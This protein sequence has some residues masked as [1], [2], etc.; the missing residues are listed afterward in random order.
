MNFQ[1]LYASD[2]IRLITNYIEANNPVRKKP[3]LF[4]AGWC[5]VLIFI[6]YQVF[7]QVMVSPTG[8]PS[9]LVICYGDGSFS[10]QIANT[11]GGTMS[12]AMLFIS[13][14]AG[15]IYTP[16]SIVGATQFNISNLNQPVF[17]LPD[18]LNNTAH[19]VSYNAGLIC[20]YTN[21]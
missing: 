17:S 8:K 5:I 12:G 2:D 11:T 21:T 20:G 6:Q 15:S 18:I 7:S 3:V 13:L 16:G 9:S 19:N 1:T 14:P 10:L 4:V